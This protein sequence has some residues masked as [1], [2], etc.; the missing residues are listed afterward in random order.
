MNKAELIA[1]KE[2]KHD[3]IEQAKVWHKRVKRLTLYKNNKPIK[4][5][6]NNKLK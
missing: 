4:F 5:N 1:F 3:E 6:Y 2:W